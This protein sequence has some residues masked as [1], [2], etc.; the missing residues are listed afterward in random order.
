[1][2][3]LARSRSSA[4]RGRCCAYVPRRAL[5]A[6]R[7]GRRRARTLP[8]LVARRQRRGAVDR[9]AAASAR[10]RCPPITIL[11]VAGRPDPARPAHRRRRSRT[12]CSKVGAGARRRPDHAPP[13]ARRRP[14]SPVRGRAARRPD[15][16]PDADR[17]RVG[18]GSAAAAKPHGAGPRRHGARGDTRLTDVASTG[19]PRLHAG[20]VPLRDLERRARR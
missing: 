8:A 2:A 9:R 18:A 1:M 5:V 17:R 13:R 10:R 11:P 7:R 6:R 14:G 16:P 15:L 20:L 19:R 12:T 4:R 3:L